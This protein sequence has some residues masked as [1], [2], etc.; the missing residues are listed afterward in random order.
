MKKY[1]KILVFILSAA[2]LLLAAGCQQADV[3]AEVNGEGITRK[4]L[5][6]RLLIFTFFMED[7]SESLETDEDFKAFIE[8]SLLNSLIQARLVNQEIER[9]DLVI[10][11]EES[12][13]YYEE[14]LEEIKLE[15]FASEEQFQSRMTELK[16]SENVLKEMIRESFLVNLLYEHVVRDIS[17]QDARD[18]FDA[19]QDIFIEPGFVRVSHILVELEEEAAEVMERLDQGEDFEDIS[20]DVSLDESMDFTIYEVDHHFDPTFTEAAFEMEV[21]TISEPVETPFGWHVIKL[22]EKEE[23]QIYNYE[24]VKEDARALKKEEVFTKY[25]TDLLESAEIK[26]YLEDL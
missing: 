7:Y 26:N 23:S 16:L 21:G 24:D 25:F 20:K 18:Y 9:M 19:N 4:H 12:E 13:K 15:F 8:S 14:E 11:E 3:L 22:H 10:D 5:D 2:I 6:E 1:S 17:E